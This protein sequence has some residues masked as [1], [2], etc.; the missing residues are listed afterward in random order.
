[1]ARKTLILCSSGAFFACEMTSLTISIGIHSKSRIAYTL[2][3]QKDS[4]I[5]TQDTTILFTFRTIQ[6]TN[7]TCFAYERTN[8]SCVI[9]RC[10]L[11][12]FSILSPLWIIWTSRASVSLSTTCFARVMT[13]IGVNLHLTNTPPLKCTCLGEV[14]NKGQHQ[15]LF[16]VIKYNAII[17]LYS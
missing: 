4:I 8:L 16:T 6:A 13:S 10:T 2:P 1:M 14:I 17:V 7:V 5:S 15:I 11:T 12:V 3:T 9:S